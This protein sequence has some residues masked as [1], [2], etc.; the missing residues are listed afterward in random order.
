[1]LKLSFL[2]SFF[3][4]SKN[5]I[6]TLDTNSFDLEPTKRMQAELMKDVF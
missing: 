4:L 1:M 6:N 2:R 5:K 3:F